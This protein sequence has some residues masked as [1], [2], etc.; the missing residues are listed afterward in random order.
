MTIQTGDIKLLKSQ[1]L[2]DTADGGGAMTSNEVID[3]QSNNLFP[4]VSALDRTY[5]R[6]SMRKAEISVVIEDAIDAAIKLPTWAG[7]ERSVEQ[8]QRE[9]EA[10]VEA[11]KSAEFDSKT[12]T[13]KMVVNI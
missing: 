1:V 11:A 10:M 13:V 2:L 6:I 5:G 4:D 7:P 12:K 3:G 8:A 9:R